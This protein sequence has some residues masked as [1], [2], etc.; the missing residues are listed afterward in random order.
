MDNSIYIE[1]EQREEQE[2]SA[3]TYAVTQLFGQEQARLSERDWLDESDLI[4]SPP[5]SAVRNL[6][7]VTIAALFRL[8]APQPRLVDLL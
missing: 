5:F 2:L 3:F 7:A 8:G 4:D 1:Q 6:R